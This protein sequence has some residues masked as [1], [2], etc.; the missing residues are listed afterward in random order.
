MVRKLFAAV[1]ALVVFVGV[2][3]AAEIKG[4]VKSVDAEKNTITVTVK[5]KDATKDVTVACNDKTK[6]ETENKDVAEKLG[7]EKLKCAACFGKPGANVTITT[8][9]EGDKA[10]AT[11]IGPV[12]IDTPF[13]VTAEIVPPAALT[14]VILMFPSLA[15]AAQYALPGQ[16][17]D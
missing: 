6:F 8:E 13:T 10:V 7:T 1:L 16:V 17:I 14:E 3:M 12:M 2:S 4:K 15:A 5:D 9:G 11:V